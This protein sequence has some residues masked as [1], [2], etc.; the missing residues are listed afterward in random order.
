MNTPEA[1]QT[2]WMWLPLPTVGSS[3]FRPHSS[4]SILR[5]LI[6]GLSH[7]ER[8]RRAGF[9][10]SAGWRCWRPPSKLLALHFKSCKRKRVHTTKCLG[11]F[12]LVGAPELPKQKQSSR[13]RRLRC[14]V[15]P[16]WVGKRLTRLLVL[17]ALALPE[18]LSSFL[19]SCCGTALPAPQRKDGATPCRFS[20]PA[21][22]LAPL[23]FLWGC[24][25][26][27]S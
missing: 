7:V 4:R 15:C 11:R 13:L 3:H 17:Q 1:P 18:T 24:R 23:V 6:I 12:S 21:S 8:A 2:S 10:V 14:A 19:R 27:T 16:S 9:Q 25:L 22:S 5:P 20:F 26:P